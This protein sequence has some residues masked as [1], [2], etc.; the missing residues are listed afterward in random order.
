MS[1]TRPSCDKD[2]VYGHGMQAMFRKL[3]SHIRDASKF[4]TK[5]RKHG[6]QAMSGPQARSQVFW[7]VSGTRYAGHILDKH[8]HDRDAA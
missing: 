7:A 5:C 3:P 8:G 6:V 4:S 1:G 2:V